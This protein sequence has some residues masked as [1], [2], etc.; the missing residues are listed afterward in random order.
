MS[1]TSA[2]STTTTPAL[3]DK[4]SRR[5]RKTSRMIPVFTTASPPITQ[6]SAK[7]RRCPFNAQPPSAT[8][9]ST[10]SAAMAHAVDHRDPPIHRTSDPT[11][12]AR[13]PTSAR[14]DLDRIVHQ[15]DDPLRCAGTA[16]AFRLGNQRYAITHAHRCARP[17]RQISNPFVPTVKRRTKTKSK[18]RCA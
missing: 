15:N 9:L 3:G 14:V 7:P 12:P 2:K 8:T 17:H 11:I 16:T 13:T 5:T 18:T 1:S 10:E 4:H 6:Q